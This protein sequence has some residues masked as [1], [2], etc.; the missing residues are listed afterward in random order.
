MTSALNIESEILGTWSYRLR[1]IGHHAP[2][3]PPVY[4]TAALGECQT[5]TLRLNTHTHTI[6]TYKCRTQ[7]SDFS[8]FLYPKECT[9]GSSEPTQIELS[10]TYEPVSCGELQ[11]VMLFVES[12]EGEVFEVPL[13]GTCTPPKPRGPIDVQGSYQLPIKNVFFSEV[14]FNCHVDNPF[15]KLNPMGKVASKHMTHLTIEASKDKSTSRVE[16]AILTVTCLT[17]PDLKW[18]YYLQSKL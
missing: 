14:Q 3:E 4:F 17:A 2:P 8:P 12:A 1:L 16:R 10:I 5:K 6:A 9:S 15:Y 7:P 11:E 18:S 13:I